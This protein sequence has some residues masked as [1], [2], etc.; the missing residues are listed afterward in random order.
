MVTAKRTCTQAKVLHEE[1]SY[2]NRD[3]RVSVRCYQ[4][5]VRRIT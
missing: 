2:N 1:N 3:D 5:F 4:D